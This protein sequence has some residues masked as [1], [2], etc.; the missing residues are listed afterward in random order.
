MAPPDVPPGMN[1]N[2]AP[3]GIMLQPTAADATL[4]NN[5]PATALGMLETF[6]PATTSFKFQRYTS[7][8]NSGA[9]WHRSYQGTTWYSWKKITSA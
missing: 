8:G 5:Y 7:Y 3:A 9:M 6:L 1:L 2:D 4:A